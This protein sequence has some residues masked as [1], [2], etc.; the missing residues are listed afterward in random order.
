MEAIVALSLACNVLTLVDFT[1]KTGKLFETLRTKGSVDP[2]LSKNAERLDNLS[3]S[4]DA[5]IV[6]AAPVLESVDSRQELLSIA[7]DCS[8]TAKELLS[9]ISKISNSR[10]GVLGKFAKAMMTSFT[11]KLKDLEKA[12]I[13]FEHALQTRLIKDIWYEYLHEQYL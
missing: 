11:G 12:M 4:L 7:R 8:K 5:S 10:A 3:K 9:V 13:Q 1:C 2:N 6:N